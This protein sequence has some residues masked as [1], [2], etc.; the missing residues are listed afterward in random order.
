MS[1]FLLL[2]NSLV[3]ALD[4]VLC[5]LCFSNSPHILFFFFENGLDPHDKSLFY[6]FT[7]LEYWVGFVFIFVFFFLF[8]QQT[9]SFSIKI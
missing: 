8:L 7:Q 2:L 5:S 6:V 4:I 3:I 1:L 9:P